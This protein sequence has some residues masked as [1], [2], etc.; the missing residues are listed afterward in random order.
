MQSATTQHNRRQVIFSTY[1]REAKR[2]K[3]GFWQV[4]SKY[5]KSRYVVVVYQRKGRMVACDLSKEKLNY[6]RVEFLLN[7]CVLLRRLTKR[8]LKDTGALEMWDK[9]RT[10][11]RKGLV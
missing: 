7:D 10:K 4:E 9:D 2:T 6:H 8:E 1:G 11:V 5:D 3:A